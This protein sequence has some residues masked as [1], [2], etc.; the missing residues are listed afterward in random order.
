M[1]TMLNQVVCAPYHHRFWKNRLIRQDDAVQ[2]PGEL[3]RPSSSDEGAKKAAAKATSAR[4][5]VGKKSDL[6]KGWDHDPRSMVWTFV[7][8]SDTNFVLY[9]SLSYTLQYEVVF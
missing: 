6:R 9:L 2:L 5:P 1:P 3:P 4:S 7:V 8:L